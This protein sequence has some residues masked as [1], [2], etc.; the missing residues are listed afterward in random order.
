VRYGQTAVNGLWTA[1]LDSLVTVED[2]HPGDYRR[3]QQ[4]MTKY[5]D[6]PMDFAYASLAAVAER[7]AIDRI[8]TVDRNHLSIYWQHNRRSITI[9]GP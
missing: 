8:F 5:T 1:V 3:M 7:L 9:L 2:M 4:L 6:L